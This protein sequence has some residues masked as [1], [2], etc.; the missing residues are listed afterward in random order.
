MTQSNK[1]SNS[2]EVASRTF[3]AS[4]PQLSQD[5]QVPDSHP[6]ANEPGVP[7][8]REY[9]DCGLEVTSEAVA[10]ASQCLLTFSLDVIWTRHRIGE[11]CLDEDQQLMY[12]VKVN[13]VTPDPR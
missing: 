4:H 6:A 11:K 10:S 7:V 12:T 9:G 8:D 5:V 1:I 13:I 2:T 3:G